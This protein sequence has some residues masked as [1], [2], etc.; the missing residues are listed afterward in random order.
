MCQLLAAGMDGEG[1][2]R[3]MK[4]S[5]AGFAISI[6]QDLTDDQWRAYVRQAVATKCPEQS[7]KV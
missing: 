6:G 3:E 7:A 5:F 1:V 2:V 4:T